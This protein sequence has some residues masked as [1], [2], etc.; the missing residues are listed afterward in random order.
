MMLNNFIVKYLI[1]F[2]RSF[3][4]CIYNF[5]FMQVGWLKAEDQT[6][7][8]LDTK[9][10]THNQRVLVSRD[11][12]TQTW[13]LHIRQLRPS[14]KGCYMCQINTSTMKKQVG[15]LDVHG[16]FFYFRLFQQLYIPFNNFIA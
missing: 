11:D 13:K 9:V 15:C 2:D 6:V 4:K 7:L 16:I 10:V 1:F 3:S 12:D 8:S 14:D 5:F